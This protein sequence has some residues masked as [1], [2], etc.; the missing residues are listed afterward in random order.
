MGKK[1]QPEY[2]KGAEKEKGEKKNGGST[3]LQK[4]WRCRARLPGA[5][6]GFCKNDRQSPPPQKTKPPPLR[7]GLK[8]KNGVPQG[9][10]GGRKKK[11]KKLK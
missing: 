5:A 2:K 9:K 6:P 11:K 7:K 8:S 3:A 4:K 10:R 1:R